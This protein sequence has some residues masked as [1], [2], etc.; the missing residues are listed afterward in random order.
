MSSVVRLERDERELFELMRGLPHSAEFTAVA[1]MQHA[2]R[3]GG[4]DWGAT[5]AAFCVFRL[6]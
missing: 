1:Q 4:T 6:L 2:V 3:T 5:S